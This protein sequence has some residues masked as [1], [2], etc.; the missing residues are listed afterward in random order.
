MRNHEFSIS[1][2][3]S[4][5]SFSLSTFWKSNIILVFPKDSEFK[6]WRKENIHSEKTLYLQI[7]MLGT[8]LK[9]CKNTENQNLG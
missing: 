9:R 7:L 8:H 4:I 3:S 6:T 1:I 2:T 5:R